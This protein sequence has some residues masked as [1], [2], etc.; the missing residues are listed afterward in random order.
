MI[1]K[2][3][4][5]FDGEPNEKT[6][7][8]KKE[9]REYVVEDETP[10]GAEFFVLE[11]LGSS[12]QTFKVTSINEMPKVESVFLKENTLREALGLRQN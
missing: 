4:V 8:V 7:K 9:K 3:V 6:G 10:S 11:Q 2:V 12:M 5:E 1:Y